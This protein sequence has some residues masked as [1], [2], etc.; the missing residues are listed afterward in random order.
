MN[1]DYIDDDEIEQTIDDTR[2]S[3]DKEKNEDDVQNHV[4]DTRRYDPTRFI[5]ISPEEVMKINEEKSFKDANP[6]FTNILNNIRDSKNRPLTEEEYFKA[7]DIYAGALAEIDEEKK[8]D[9]EG[10]TKINPIKKDQYLRLLLE[11]KPVSIAASET[12]RMYESDKVNEVED[13]YKEAIRNESKVIEIKNGKRINF[14]YKGKCRIASD[15]SGKV[16]IIDNKSDVDLLRMKYRQE[17][18]DKKYPDISTPKLIRKDD[19]DD[20]FV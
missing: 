6:G 1:E 13:A 10:E 9:Y 11:N 17:W 12:M 2:L 20:D 8:K 14:R 3:V 19:G 5:V 16:V 18:I 15:E 7:C 4:T